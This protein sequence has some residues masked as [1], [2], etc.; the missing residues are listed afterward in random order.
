M[1]SDVNAATISDTPTFYLTPP[2]TF[3]LFSF[4]SFSLS[5]SQSPLQVT[6]NKY[7]LNIIG[8]FSRTIVITLQRRII[9]TRGV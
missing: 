5:L 7:T 6:G 3:L 2:P 1:S 8:E 4:L 9:E